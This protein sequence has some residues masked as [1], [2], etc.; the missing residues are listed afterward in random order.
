MKVCKRIARF[1]VFISTILLGSFFLGLTLLFSAAFVI[2]MLDEQFVL[3]MTEG[4]LYIILNAGL[5]LLVLAFGIYLG[6]K[7]KG[8]YD[9]H[10]LS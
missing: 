2:A 10:T 3:A 6:E 1:L 4:V 5:T 8:G 9:G 7:F